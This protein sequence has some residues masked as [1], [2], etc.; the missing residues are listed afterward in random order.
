MF[1][2]AS[3]ISAALAKVTAK[4]K[5]SSPAVGQG[6]NDSFFSENSLSESRESSS[7]LSRNSSSMGSPDCSVTG[8]T[9]CNGYSAAAPPHTIRESG[10]L[11]P[12][13]SFMA[14][15]CFVP[16]SYV[17]ACTRTLCQ[18][19]SPLTFVVS[20]VFSSSFA[21][22]CSANSSQQC[23]CARL[24]TSD[25]WS[26][27]GEKRYSI[28]VSEEDLSFKRSSGGGFVLGG[29]QGEENG[30]ERRVKSGK[31]FCP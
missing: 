15:F 16:H 6:T 30:P 26:E 20:I 27:R 22:P 13:V 19:F 2:T 1:L 11:L 29:K 4:R 8:P 9:A 12:A 21:C 14:H 10:F 18:S 23:V 24:L 28:L 5:H 31:T 17:F 3:L 7:S 25:D